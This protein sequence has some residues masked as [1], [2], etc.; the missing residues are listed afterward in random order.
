MPLTAPSAQPML[1]QR[2]PTTKNM[3]P[4]A[5]IDHRSVDSQHARMRDHRDGDRPAY[6]QGC[7]PRP[8][9][10][11]CMGKRGGV[12][13]SWSRREGFLTFTRALMSCNRACMSASRDLTELYRKVIDWRTVSS[14][15]ATKAHDRTA[16]SMFGTRSEYH[17]PF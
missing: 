13:C 5:P 10:C 15:A 12:R 6:I 2:R 4:R 1:R 11:G 3:V 16:R 17:S 14:S 9:P 8:L 7:K